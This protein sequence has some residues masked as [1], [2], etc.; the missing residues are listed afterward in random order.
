MRRSSKRSP[1]SRRTCETGAAQLAAELDYIAAD[2]HYIA[3][4]VDYIA[5]D[6][7]RIFAAVVVT[8]AGV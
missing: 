4:D 8:P 3:A 2:V 1:R 7:D 6:V 5:A